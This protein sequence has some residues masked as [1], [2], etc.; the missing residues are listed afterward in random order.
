MVEISP[1]KAIIIIFIVS[2]NPSCPFLL[3]A[4]LL[5]LEAGRIFSSVHFVKL[6]LDDSLITFSD[7]IFS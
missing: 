3:S 5:V 2:R 7:K 1:G 4:I 6:R